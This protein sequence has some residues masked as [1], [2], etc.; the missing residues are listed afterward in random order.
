MKMQIHP[1]AA[2][3]IYI[4]T[5]VCLELSKEFNTVGSANLKNYSW[6]DW[7]VLGVSTMATV[8]L[9]IKSYI[10]PSY[11]DYRNGHNGNGNPPPVVEPPNPPLPP[12]AP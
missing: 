3:F 9:V 8:G 4:L 1:F 5:T 12:V 7:L 11:H 6:I 10:D 2:L